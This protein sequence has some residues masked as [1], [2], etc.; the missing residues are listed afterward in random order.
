LPQL[1]CL[2]SAMAR[3]GGGRGHLTFLGD[4]IDRG[5]SSLACARSAARPAE[6]LGFE[7]RTVLLGNHEMLMLMAVSAR[8]DAADAQDVWVANGGDRTLAEAGQTPN[9]L[10][11]RTEACRAALERAL[12]EKASH[13]VSSAGL[14]R[15]AGNVL[16]VHAGIDPGVTLARA[17]DRPRLTLTDDRHPCWIRFPF[18]YHEGGF[19]GGRIVVHGH[20]PEP[21][22]LAG[23][24]RRAEVGYHRLDGSRLG[25]DGGS[26][27]TGV[28]AGAEFRG[29]GYRV[30]T[31][32]AR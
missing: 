17:L 28:V 2:L 5:P 19:E 11:L 31:A 9:T 1:E 8:P 24:G 14:S 20:T 16:F 12:G 7:G 23:K 25:L 10:V 13:T 18:L 21:R 30:F 29:G 4:L 32:S 15:Q 22:V 3:A 27:G 6:V 26:Y